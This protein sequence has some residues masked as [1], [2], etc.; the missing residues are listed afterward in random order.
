ME[1]NQ[2]IYLFQNKLKD[3]MF[4]FSSQSCQLNSVFCKITLNALLDLLQ[5]FTMYF[6][7]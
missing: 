7:M 1:F 3:D 6:T 5:I 2:N 4:F